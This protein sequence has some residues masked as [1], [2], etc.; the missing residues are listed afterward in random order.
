MTD[1]E[2]T[3][4]NELMDELLSR[5]EAAVVVFV[6][7]NNPEFV[8]YRSTGGRTHAI[9]LAESAAFT[10]KMDMHKAEEHYGALDPETGS[11]QPDDDDG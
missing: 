10:W 2:T 5:C 7:K 3:P 8:G 9:G 4:T 6:P 1:L 11:D